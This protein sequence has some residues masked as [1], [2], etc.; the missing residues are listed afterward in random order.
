RRHTRPVVCRLH[1][2]RSMRRSS[3]PGSP[4]SARPASPHPSPSPKPPSTSGRNSANSASGNGRRSNDRD[5]AR[6]PT[7]GGI[8]T[9]W[10]WAFPRGGAS[11]LTPSHL[12]DVGQGIHS[13]ARRSVR[14]MLALLLLIAAQAAQ[15]TEPT[16]QDVKFFAHYDREYVQLRAA[17]AN[18]FD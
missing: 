1:V 8:F 15:P 18:L 17:V 7:P 13:F 12:L 4:P 10:P 6:W 11:R 5:A 16:L 9:R 3:R 2:P 14:Q